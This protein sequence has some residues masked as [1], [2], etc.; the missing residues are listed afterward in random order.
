MDITTII[1]GIS[2]LTS[3]AYTGFMHFDCCEGKILFKMYRPI[4]IAYVWLL[5]AGSG[6]HVVTC[7]IPTASECA[8]CNA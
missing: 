5:K 3:V 7:P 4:F 1:K 2:K 8:V 6:A